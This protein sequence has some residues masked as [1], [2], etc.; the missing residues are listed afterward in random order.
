MHRSREVLEQR[1]VDHEVLLARTEAA[2][3]QVRGSRQSRG[4]R[5]AALQEELWVREQYVAMLRATETEQELPGLG[6]TDEM[7]REV[8]LGDSLAAAWHRFGPPPPG[9]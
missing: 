9:W 2:I 6:L 5:R 7:I 1:L 8:R 3:Q 4:E